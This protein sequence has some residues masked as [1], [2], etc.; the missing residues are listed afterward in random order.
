MLHQDCFLVLEGLDG[1]GKSELSRRLRAQLSA[2]YGE[3]VLLTYEPY[4]PCVA[5]DYLRQALRKEIVVSNR[6]LALAY[7]LNRADHLD[8]VIDPFLRG[9]GCVVIC[10][11]YL[12]SSLVYQTR[13]GM[14]MD[15]VLLLNAGA[16]NP[17]LTLFLDVT[18]ETSRQRLQGRQVKELF[19]DQLEEMRQQY[20]AA[21]RY[22]EDRGETIRVIDANGTID[23]VLNA[24]SA[25]LA[26]FL[27]PP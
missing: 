4:D 10:D 14:S 22:L 25:A 15:D 21:I 12:L 20:H 5:G 24:V 23:E 6:T 11:R 18:P 19:D 1:S 8:R 7:A 13:D 27:P 3:R 26:P 2:I 17:D 16:R 9:A